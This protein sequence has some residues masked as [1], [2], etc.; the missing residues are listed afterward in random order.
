[1]PP[2]PMGLMIW[3]LPMVL[4]SAMELKF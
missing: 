3:Y 4:G 1:M 2:W